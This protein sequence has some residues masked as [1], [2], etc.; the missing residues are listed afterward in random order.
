VAWYDA[1]D[2]STITEAAGAV[3]QWDDKSNNSFDVVQGTGANQPTYTSGEYVE[4]DGNDFLLLTTGV[5]AFNNKGA[6][7]IYSVVDVVP[8]ASPQVILHVSQ[9]DSTAV[10]RLASI[11]SIAEDVRLSSTRLDSEGVN[12]LNGDTSGVSGEIIAGSIMDWTNADG[13]VYLNGTEDGEDLAFGT[14]G[15]T[16]NT[17]SLELSVGAANGGGIRWFQSYIREIV[18]VDVVDTDTRQRI[19]GYL[20]WKWNL[21]DELPVDHPYKNHPPEDDF[22]FSSDST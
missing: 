3:S 12:G 19:E 1:A 6:G 18:A 11:I 5:D 15:S 7:M 8:T 10:P 14:S 17:N 4:F 16:S 22:S 2:A 21:E 9:G 13:W 20:A